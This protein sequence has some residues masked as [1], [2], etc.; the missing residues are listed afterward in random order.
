MILEGFPVGPVGAN[1]YIFGDDAAGEVF[2]IDPGDEPER[3]LNTVRRLN[4][5]PIAIV[6]THGHFDHVQGVD[7]VR[8]ATGAPFWI[9]E[10]EREVLEQGPARA[11]MLF[12][13]DLPPSPAPDRWLRDGDRL[14]VGTLTLTVRH[15][16]GHSPGGICLLGEGLA[17]TG[18]TLFAGSIGRADLPGADLETLLTSIVRVLLPLP[19][20]T[21]CYPGHGPKTT[22]GEEKRTNPFLAP[23]VRGARHQATGR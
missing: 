20:D 22:I 13:V 23:L 12:G 9:H 5:R 4:V 2:I 16:P 10:A 11:R 6:N 1:C 8:R 19:D 3:I 18:D 14:Q 15:T 17:F 7:E 21:V